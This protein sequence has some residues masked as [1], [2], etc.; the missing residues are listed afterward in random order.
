MFTHRNGDSTVVSSSP[1]MDGKES[2][3][4]W[5][6]RRLKGASVLAA[7]VF[8]LA[9]PIQMLSATTASANTPSDWS[10]NYQGV[11]IGW[12]SNHA[13]A[14]ASYATVAT[15]GSGEVASLAC[16]AAP[17]AGPVC[18]YIMETVVSNLVAGSA[19]F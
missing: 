14:I 12:T 9:L 8:A 15:L 13:W 10:G 6:R 18:S 17:G 16:S 7:A 1:S 4:P 2:R 19:R 3:R 5:M 11:E